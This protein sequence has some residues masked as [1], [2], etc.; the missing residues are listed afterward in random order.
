M[1]FSEEKP[2]SSSE[3]SESFYPGKRGVSISDQETC[4][5]ALALDYEARFCGHCNTTT[6][7][8]EANYFGR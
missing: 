7:I 4:W 2:E 6:D 5:R 3:P 8:K 1:I